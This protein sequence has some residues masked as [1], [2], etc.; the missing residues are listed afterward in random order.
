MNCINELHI[1]CVPNKVR[2]KFKS[3]ADTIQNK[4]STAAS[5]YSPI[6]GQLIIRPFIGYSVILHGG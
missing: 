2:P 1:H 4:I 5:F 6:L 3:E